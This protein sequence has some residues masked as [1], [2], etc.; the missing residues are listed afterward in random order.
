MRRLPL[1]QGQRER[2]RSFERASRS[3][4]SEVPS[5]FGS[6]VV[7]VTRSEARR[8]LPPPD[9]RRSR[10]RRT[11][12]INAAASCRCREQRHRY[13]T[14]TRA[15]SSARRH[16]SRR[17][18][19]RVFFF[20]CLF[21]VAYICWGRLICSRGEYARVSFPIIRWRLVASLRYIVC[22]FLSRFC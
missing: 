4:V 2:E 1:T 19:A 16:C 14:P 12:G 5:L 13:A 7:R 17:T 10:G 20:P 8:Q 18:A 6:V 22:V 15:P 11:R 9:R 21:L 3:R